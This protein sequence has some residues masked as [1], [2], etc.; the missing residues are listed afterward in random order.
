MEGKEDNK[1]AF[2]KYKKIFSLGGEL[3][4]QIEEFKTKKTMIHINF[5]RFSGIEKSF[6]KITFPLLQ[7]EFPIDEKKS[8][9]F[10]YITDKYLYINEFA[11]KIILSNEEKEEEHSIN[12]KKHHDNYYDFN[13]NIDKGKTFS[14]EIVFYFKD[15]KDSLENIVVNDKKIVS[16]EIFQKTKR[17]N[18]ININQNNLK[19][20]FDDYSDNKI[21]ELNEEQQNDLFKWKNLFLN[22]IYGVKKRI[23]KIFYINEEK[24]IED[25][26]E[27]EKNILK[28]INE[29][30]PDENINQ[31][32]LLDRLKALSENN[33]YFDKDG[34]KI[35]NYLDDLNQKF[36]NMPIFQKYY[37]KNPTE[38]DFKI[39][40]A[41]AILNIFLYHPLEHLTK[42][43]R[44]I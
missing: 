11:E 14:L 9:D 10:E 40:R 21:N 4:K 34:N 41:A 35:G 44:F 19:K 28:Q 3:Q 33:N 22:F 29:I 16:N 20:L 38:E 43:L 13:I 2:E 27:K 42:M 37:N 24:E 1:L 39:I 5:F 8:I 30:I 36:K 23:G 15:T 26:D 12:I 18:L 7:K 32:V 31:K 17:Y 6:K 25:F